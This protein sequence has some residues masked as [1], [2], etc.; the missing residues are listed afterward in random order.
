MVVEDSNLSGMD[1]IKHL[2]WRAGFGLSAEEW[3]ERRNWSISQAVNH[4][5]EAAKKAKPPV[6]QSGANTPEDTGQ[7]G[8]EALLEK[9]KE[10]RKLVALQ[11]SD[12]LQRMADPAQSALLERVALF[13][14]G[15]FAC[16]TRFSL[17]A[18]AQLNTL[19]THALGSFRELTVAMAR[20]VSMIRFLNNQQ[21]RKDRPN[22]NFARELMELFTIGR[23]NYTEKDVK[24]A[25][26]AFTGW[27]SNLRGEFLFRPGQHDYGVKTFMGQSGRFDGEDIIDRLLEKRATAEFITRKVY[28]YFVSEQVDEGIVAGLSKRFYES[29]YQTETLLREIFESDWFYAPKNMGSK[30]KSPAD[31]LAGILRKLK[32]RFENELS[33][34]FVQRALGQVLFNPPN[35]AG[36]P[37]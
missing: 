4:L 19:R 18:T 6:A 20:D 13:W 21:N 34:V 17:L 37:V 24:E 3:T 23:G 11:G 29:D 31:L 14:H 5:F 35:V 22:E 1:H 32:I 28:R 9:I 33:L 8:K 25:A 15:H 26:R 12:W 7:P 2:F 30:I 10:E 16:Q 27:S 36:W